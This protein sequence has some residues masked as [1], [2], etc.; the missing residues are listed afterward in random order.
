MGLNRIW[1]SEFNKIE[2]NSSMRIEKN[3][4]KLNELKYNLKL[5]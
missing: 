2:W 5:K 4:I 3:R 1:I